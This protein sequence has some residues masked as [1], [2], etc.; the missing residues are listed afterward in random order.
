MKNKRRY[1]VFHIS[2]LRK[3]V[4]PE[5]DIKEKKIKDQFGEH[6][7]IEKILD[8]EEWTMEDNKIIIFYL[9]QYKD[10]SVS[11]EPEMNLKNSKE[12][13][14][15]FKGLMKNKNGPKQIDKKF[16]KVSYDKYPILLSKEDWKRNMK[17]LCILFF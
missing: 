5:E 16:G 2:K 6:L 7:E 14:K 11:Y 1:N 4:Q 17:K 9:I 10:G 13:L 3:Y 8:W 15:K 12:K